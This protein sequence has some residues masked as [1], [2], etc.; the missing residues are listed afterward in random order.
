MAAGTAC[1]RT[2]WP[3]LLRAAATLAP[4][5]RAYSAKAATS[6][7]DRARLLWALSGGTHVVYN[8]L[9]SEWRHSRGLQHTGP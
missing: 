9:G 7:P 5:G 2:E 4:N 6:A 3:R 8:T 1:S